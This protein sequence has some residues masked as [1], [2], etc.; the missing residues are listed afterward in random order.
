MKVP[1][2]W[3][4][5][6]LGLC[7]ALGWVV[8]CATTAQVSDPAFRPEIQNPA[9]S[10]TEGPVVCLDEG[11]LNFHTSTGRYL[12]F[13]QLL[14]QD[15]YVVRGVSQ[16]LSTDSLAGCQVLVIANAISMANQK[17]WKL[18]ASPAFS[19]AEVSSVAQWV[20]DGRSLLLIADHMPFPGSTA[21]LA[22]AFGVLFSNGFAADESGAPSR[23][24]F[25]TTDGSLQD[26]PITRGRTPE[27]RVDSV[28]TFVGQAF[29]VETGSDVRPLLVLPRG[30]VLLLPPKAWKFSEKTPILPA[31]GMLQGA[32]GEVGKGRVAV[33][34]EAAMF[35]AQVSGN[36]KPMGM[37]SPD[38]AQNVQFLLNVLHWLSGILPS[39]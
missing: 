4:L 9:Y 30:A 15:G 23:L 3:D 20:R 35:S 18:P 32:A 22:A 39:S 34:G 38:A 19:E 13:A 5:R 16:H 14:R 33:F 10:A 31:A 11:H 25:T 21:D 26:H 8:G 7:A 24:T 27:E 17:H 6:R 29:R 36:G 1:T 37:N 28:M 2:T 12:P